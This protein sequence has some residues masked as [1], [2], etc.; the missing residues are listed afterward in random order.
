MAY[1]LDDINPIGKII[2]V[3]FELI[4]LFLIKEKIVIFSV[5]TMLVII[6]LTN[7]R[8]LRKSISAILG[9]SPLFFTIFL[10]GFIFGTSWQRDLMIILK[11]AILVCF[12]TILIYTTSEY[13]FLKNV[14]AILPS[15]LFDNFIIFIYGIINFIPIF[16]HQFSETIIAYK[17]QKGK[18]IRLS[19]ISPLFTSFLEKSIIRTKSLSTCSEILISSFP[20]KLVP[21]AAQ[22]SGIALEFKPIDIVIPSIIMLQILL[23][24][25]I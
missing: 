11:I 10:L 20:I 25:L 14:R 16:N 15:K 21:N 19:D 22:E 24:I 23:F 17:L 12:T 18:K 5:L 13:A 6:F 7:L 2:F 8:L 1:N 9:L 3:F 4:G